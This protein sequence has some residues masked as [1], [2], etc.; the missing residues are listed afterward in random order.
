MLGMQL[1]LGLRYV[2][3]NVWYRRIVREP[4][5]SLTLMTNYPLVATGYSLPYKCYIITS[6]I[7]RILI[8]Y[9]FK[10]IKMRTELVE[11][12]ERYSF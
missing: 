11:M 5:I 1:G 12:N 10:L 8:S 3:S 2:V 7:N 4:L 9:Q 6:Y